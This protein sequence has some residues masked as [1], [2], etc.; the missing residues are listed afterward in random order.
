LSNVIRNVA[1]RTLKPVL[2]ID[3]A[4]FL[5]EV[6]QNMS[7]VWAKDLL[8]KKSTF[9]N[10]SALYKIAISH[11]KKYSLQTLSNAKG[12]VEHASMCPWLGHIAR[13][14]SDSAIRTTLQ[15]RTAGP[16]ARRQR[17]GHVCRSCWPQR[18]SDWLSR[19]STR[20]YRDI[21]IGWSHLNETRK[22]RDDAKHSPR[23]DAVPHARE[24]RGLRIDNSCAQRRQVKIYGVLSCADS[25]RNEGRRANVAVECETT[26]RPSDGF[27]KLY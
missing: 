8:N 6:L 5:S 26:R 4:S 1:K 21:P 14:K 15:P 11:N 17:I 10:T 9:F 27:D 25:H 24:A 7:L 23:V 18:S 22:K 3:L 19:R 13:P 20:P 2:S 16:G 12:A